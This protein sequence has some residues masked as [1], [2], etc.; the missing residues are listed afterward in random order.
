MYIGIFEL[1][2]DFSI[3]TTLLSLVNPLAM[4]LKM[5]TISDNNEGE[6]EGVKEGRTLNIRFLPGRVKNKF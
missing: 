6:T 3:G 1:A 5:Q 2:L 4:S